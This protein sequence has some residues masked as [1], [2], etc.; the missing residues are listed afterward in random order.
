[1]WSD[2]MADLS[3]I[4]SHNMPLS[5]TGPVLHIHWEKSKTKWK[6]SKTHWYD[7]QKPAV[8]LT[9]SSKMIK[10]KFLCAIN[11]GKKIKIFSSGWQVIYIIFEELLYRS[12]TPIRR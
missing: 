3:W 1:M 11:I 8:L 4:V 2:A 5:R 10:E 12:F 6:K 9:C 7:S